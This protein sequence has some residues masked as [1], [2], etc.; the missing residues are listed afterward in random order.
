MT[1]QDI[2]NA[3]ERHVGIR[4]T[5]VRSVLRRLREAGMFPFGAP[6]T[7]PTIA[8]NDAITLFVAVATGATLETVADATRAYLATTPGGADVDGAPLSIPRTAEIALATLAGAIDEGSELDGLT[9]EIVQTWPEVALIWADGIV[10]RFQA[11]G[12]IANHHQNNRG[13]TAVR[14]PGAAFADFIRSVK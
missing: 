11:A 10:Q 6:G 8:R 9:I 4:A 12:T 1:P 2:V 13:R 3:I 14:I 5:R 7:P